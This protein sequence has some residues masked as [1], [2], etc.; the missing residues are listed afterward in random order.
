MYASDTF[1]SEKG[2]AKGDGIQ[3]TDV[4]TKLL[5]NQADVVSV[6]A[7]DVCLPVVCVCVTSIRF[8]NAHE[9]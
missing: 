6:L 9:H 7:C 3:G 8:F 1:D 5:S 4:L 2:P